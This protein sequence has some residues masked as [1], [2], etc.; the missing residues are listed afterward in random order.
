MS[1]PW[2]TGRVLL[3]LLFLATAVFPIAMWFDPMH[4]GDPALP[5]HA[6]FH[7]LWKTLLFTI[8]GVA[9]AGGAVWGW[10]PGGPRSWLRWVPAVLWLTHPIA[11]VAVRTTQPDNPFPHHTALAGPV[12]VEDL[13]IVGTLLVSVVAALLDRRDAR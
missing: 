12:A 6:R 1:V 13:A 4:L 3:L 10:R 9:G 5:A 7:M 8:L 11:H 2:R